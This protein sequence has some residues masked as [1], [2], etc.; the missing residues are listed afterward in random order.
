VP[1]NPDQKTSDH[2]WNL[3]RE[4]ERLR[5]IIEDLKNLGIRVSLFIDPD[6]DQIKLAPETGTDRIELYTEEYARLYQ[7][8]KADECF[9]KYSAAVDLARELGLGINAGHDLNL[10]N[11]KKFCSIPGILEVS[12]G[13]ALI[14]DAL[15]MGL[16]N[17]VKAYC[18]ELSI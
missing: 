17:A 9:Q 10:L 14:S 16:G 12:I 7:T 4:K 2:G 13:H 6:M 8:E 1:D 3:K 18:R 15:N 5:P 11:L